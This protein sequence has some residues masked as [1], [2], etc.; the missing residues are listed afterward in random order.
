MATVKTCASTDPTVSYTDNAYGNTSDCTFVFGITWGDNSGTTTITV[1]D[2]TDGPHL[3]ATHRYAGARVYTITVN[4]QVT[5]GNCTGNNSVH[6]FTLTSPTATVTNRPWNGYTT[7]WTQAP[8]TFY[9]AGASWQV[10]HN[11]CGPISI[12]QNLSDA[13]QWVG[14]GGVG[15]PVIQVGVTSTC[16][17]GLQ[18][19]AAVWEVTP[20]DVSVNPII[21]LVF[22]GNQMSASVEYLG[23][24][25]YFLSLRDLT[26]GW[27]WSMTVSGPDYVPDTADWAVEAGGVPL[28]DFGSV[29][30]TDCTYA[31]G[32][33]GAVFL[34]GGINPVKFETKGTKGLETQVS[35]I[36]A[37]GTFT[38][39]YLPS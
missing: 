8:K 23:G 28:A 11:N 25:K 15:T 1:T 6:T 33:Q 4:V 24:G 39:T 22:P 16:Q 7:N 17:Y 36:T 5:A 18:L 29:M 20:P 35:G 32:H 10:P 21:H 34:T 30:F 37:G 27:N 19:N 38:V 26:R 3:L 9:V 13:G 14:L 12:H 31:T 2:P